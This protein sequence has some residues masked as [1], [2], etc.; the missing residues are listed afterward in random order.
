MD[1]EELGEKYAPPTRILEATGGGRKW[2][3][4]AFI[5]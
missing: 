4:V 5:S 3:E 1:P 2:L